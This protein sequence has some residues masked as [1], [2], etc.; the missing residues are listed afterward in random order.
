MKPHATHRRRPFPAAASER[1]GYC[2]ACFARIDADAATCP[3]C[4]RDLARLSEREHRDKL[5]A[6]LDHPLADVRLRAIIALGW[7]GEGETAL[8]LVWCALRHPVDVVEGLQVIESLR[9]IH[10]MAARQ[11]AVQLLAERHPARVVRERAADVLMTGGRTDTPAGLL[12][13]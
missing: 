11:S 9:N 8:A 7:R 10:D 5:L 6:A 13:H 4:G 3:V 1:S 2:P 12:A